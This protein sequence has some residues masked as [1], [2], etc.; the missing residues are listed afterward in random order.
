[1]NYSRLRETLIRHEGKRLCPYRDSVGKLTIGV[2]RN[3]DDRGIT[4]AEAELLLTQDLLRCEDELRKH[5]SFF[6][7]LNSPRQEVLTNMCFNLGLEGLMGFRNM[8]SSLQRAVAGGGQ[9]IFIEAADHMLD[10]KWAKQVGTRAGEL[11]R[12]MRDGKWI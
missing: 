6:D 11:A 10:S 8:L 9:A 1:M 5:L 7:Q 4:D 12:V 3:L 2:G